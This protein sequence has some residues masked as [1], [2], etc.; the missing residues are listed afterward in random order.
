MIELEKAYL[1]KYLPPGLDQCKK[2]EVMDIYLPT[3]QRHPTLRIRK[4]GDKYEITKKEP[5]IDDP[6]EMKE[7]TTTLTKEE[8]EELNRSV[9]GKRLRKIRY[10][11]PY[12]NRITEIDV[13]QDQLHGLIIIDFEF[14]SIEEKNS[15]P[16]PEFCLA[17]ITK[18]EF[19]AGGMLCGKS[20]AEIENVLGKYGYQKIS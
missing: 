16:M 2:K 19:T 14:D 9:V 3:D 8:F 15:F 10:Y 6:S 20:Y 1:A 4:N 17:D 11:Y 12:Q 7:E 5:L 18:E 13:F